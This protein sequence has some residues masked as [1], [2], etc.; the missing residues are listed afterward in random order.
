MPV[1]TVVAP[2]HIGGRELLAGV[3]DAVAGA[4]DLGPA[5]VIAMCVPASQAVV[6]GGGSPDGE[7]PLVSIHGTDRGLDATAAA[8][9]AA[10]RAVA[11]WGRTHAI[12]IEGVWCEWLLPQ[13]Q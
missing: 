6:N 3:A 9:D 2:A 7:W 1:V 12:A 4:L 8:R 5:D 10:T 13:P 11:D